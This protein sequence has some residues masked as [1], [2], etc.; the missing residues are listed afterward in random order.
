MQIERSRLLIRNS[1]TW[2]NFANETEKCAIQVV[3]LFND[4][5]NSM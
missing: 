3:L 4:P 2:A 1:H 5:L